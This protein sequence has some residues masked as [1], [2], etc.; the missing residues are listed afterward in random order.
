MLSFTAAPD[1]VQAHQPK[2]VLGGQLAPPAQ[3][4]ASFW[5]G[6]SQNTLMHVHVPKLVVWATAIRLT[7]LS[8]LCDVIVKSG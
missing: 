5:L 6:G 3:A 4:R 1:K 8:E 2:P 7:Q